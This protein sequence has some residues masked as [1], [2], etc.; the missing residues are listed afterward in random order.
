MYKQAVYACIHTCRPCMCVYIHA[1]RVCV[2]HESV[3]ARL[4]CE[5]T[6]NC[7]M[8]AFVSV[9][10]YVSCTHTKHCVHII[11]SICLES[12][13]HV[14]TC[15]RQTDRQEPGSK[16]DTDLG[17]SRRSCTMNLCCPL[18]MVNCTTDPTGPCMWGIKVSRV[19]PAVDALPT[20]T[21][22]SP[23]LRLMVFVC[24]MC[25]SCSCTCVCVCV[26][27]LCARI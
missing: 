9:C 1:G 13:V 17:L 12:K 8:P 14:H 2:C 10:V 7:G 23:G 15:I 27:V 5:Y 24:V 16:T 19:M 6:I 18:A 4:S 3:R 22:R 26:C 20:A 21:R 25:L 11:E